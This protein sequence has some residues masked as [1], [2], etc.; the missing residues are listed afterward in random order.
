[1]KLCVKYVTER[2]LNSTCVYILPLGVFSLVLEDLTETSFF[3]IAFSANHQ[4]GN[5]SI[6]DLTVKEKIQPV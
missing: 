1:M 2:V 5:C 3:S 4:E 6:A